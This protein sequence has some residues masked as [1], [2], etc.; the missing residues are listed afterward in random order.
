MWFVAG[1]R[2]DIGNDSVLVMLLFGRKLWAV[3]W[4]GR[5]ASHLRWECRCRQMG[6]WVCVARCLEGISG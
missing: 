4:I 3:G 5:G 2:R 1:A 6:E